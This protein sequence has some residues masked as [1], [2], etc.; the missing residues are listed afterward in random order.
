[1]EV[2]NHAIQGETP[3]ILRYRWRTKA[4]EYLTCEAMFILEI[5]EG[6]VVGMFGISRGVSQPSQP[7]TGE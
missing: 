7:G 6:K 5:R 3:P 4:G 2:F 1:M